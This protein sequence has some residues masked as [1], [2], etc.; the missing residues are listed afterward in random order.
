MSTLMSGIDKIVTWYSRQP[1]DFSDINTLM[2]ARQ[3]LACLLA[4]M[5]A[6]LKDLYQQKCATEFQRK[7]AYSRFISEEMS[8][9]K[10]SAA[11]AKILADAK[12]E[13]YLERE[14]QAEAEYKGSWILYDAYRNVCDTM[15][16]HISN[17]KQERSR[18]LSGQ[19]SAN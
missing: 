15:N 11:A 18:D 4:E 6:Q 17:L 8:V 10:T 19:G 16:Q 9:E 5:A 3:K 12:I 7:A 2:A 13:E 1:R 14:Y